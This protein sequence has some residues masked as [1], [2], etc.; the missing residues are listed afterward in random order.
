MK[1]LEIISDISNR[2]SCRQIFENYNMLTLF[3]L[4]ILYILEVI[5]VHLTYRILDKVFLLGTE[6]LHVRS[7][8][9]FNF[10]LLPM[11]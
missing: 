7:C 8:T 1:V 9:V 6:S 11:V 10:L 3:P 2:M 4:Y 5:H